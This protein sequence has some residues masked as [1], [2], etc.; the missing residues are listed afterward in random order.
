MTFFIT[1]YILFVLDW[2][3]R[4]YGGDYSIPYLE[5]LGHADGGRMGR[6][7]TRRT[8]SVGKVSEKGDFRSDIPRNEN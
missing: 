3:M 4:A 7:R 5:D 6:L 1:C 2:L 8:L